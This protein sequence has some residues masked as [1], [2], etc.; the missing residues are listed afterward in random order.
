MIQGNL[1]IPSCLYHRCTV[2]PFQAHGRYYPF[3]GDIDNQL[4]LH[5]PDEEVEG[6]GGGA[7]FELTIFKPIQIGIYMRAHS[8]LPPSFTHFLFLL[9]TSE[10]ACFSNDPYSFKAPGRGGRF[11][12]ISRPLIHLILF[13]RLSRDTKEYTACVVKST[14][15]RMGEEI[16]GS[17]AKVH[18]PTLPFQSLERC[19]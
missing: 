6:G 8:S 12:L 4:V 19:P 16:L 7:F 17:K 13:C 18:H 5:I 10:S 11:L 3:L 1:L 2:Q 14:L 15:D 9:L